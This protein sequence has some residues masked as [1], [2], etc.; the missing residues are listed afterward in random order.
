MRFYI[1]LLFFYIGFA[2]LSG[3]QITEVIY[4]DRP[5]YRVETKN[6][7]Y[8]YDAVAG[9]F[10]T[11][12]DLT[13]KDWIA[14]RDQPRGN[15][16][17]AAASSFRGIPNLIYGGDDDGAGHPGHK[18][19]RSVFEGDRITSETLSGKWSWSWTFTE[20][21]ARLDVE[22]TDGDTPY[23]FLYEGPAGGK[24]R[25]K[26]TSW[27]SDLSGPNYDRF[28]H[29][30]GSKHEGSYRW[31]Y[32]N[33]PDSPYTFWMAQAK[34]DQLPDHYSLL[35][36]EEKGIDSADGM[37]VAGFGRTAPAKPLLIGPNSFYIGFFRKSVHNKGRHRAINRFIR[38][39]ID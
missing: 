36:N 34:A 33:G 1:L 35:G 37:I 5:H 22:K 39:R 16:P 14:Y 10:S 31:M 24:Y 27:G 3:Q 8:F 6:A 17:A 15:Y 9:G 32:F 25:P 28:D 20:E 4:L 23:W 19:C 13:G 38:K 12:T 30:R 2:S 18:K 26:Q 21:Y 7:I 29:Y 11:I